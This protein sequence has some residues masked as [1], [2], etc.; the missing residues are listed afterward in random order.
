MVPDVLGVPHPTRFAAAVVTV[1]VSLV[2][3]MLLIVSV[4]RPS[5]ACPFMIV[6]VGLP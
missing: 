6:V 3:V 5:V 2:R 1:I 4:R